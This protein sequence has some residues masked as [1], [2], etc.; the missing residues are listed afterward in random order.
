MEILKNLIPHR[1]ARMTLVAFL[2]QICSL[3]GLIAVNLVPGGQHWAIGIGYLLIYALFFALIGKLC[4]TEQADDFSH[5][6]RATFC[7]LVFSVGVYVSLFDTLSIFGWYLIIMGTFHYSEYFAT[8]ITN[9]CNLS[10]DSF[11]L[12][13]SPAYHIAAVLSW[14]EFFLE[15]YF[16]PPLKSYKL[17]S[18][19]GVIPV[20]GGEILRKVAMVHAGRSFSHIVQ[21]EKRDDHK[22]VTSGVFSIMRH[23]SYVGWFYWSIGTQI[24]LCNPV[25]VVAYAIVSWLFFNERTYLE[26]QTLLAF[27]Q[28]EYEEYKKRV[29]SGLPM[30]SGYPIEED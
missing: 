2:I 16:Y 26:E 8:A 3:V 30:I 27:F 11:L 20:L 9:P 13:H 17:I 6:W 28:E 19:L 4:E 15:W 10:T 5:W 12:N 21:T 29:P 18:A 7:G 25:C 14:I 1:L 22:L 24:V 23:P